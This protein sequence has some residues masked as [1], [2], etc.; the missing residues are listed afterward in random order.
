MP[1][2]QRRSARINRTLT[3]RAGDPGHSASRDQTVTFAG[4]TSLPGCPA[5]LPGAAIAGRVLPQRLSPRPCYLADCRSELPS[6][7]SGAMQPR[8]LGGNTAGEV[9]RQA[10]D[11]DRDGGN[12]L[13]RLATYGQHGVV[14]AVPG[15]Q[16]RS[17]SLW[18]ELPCPLRA[19]YGLGRRTRIR[20]RPATPGTISGDYAL[21][22]RT[23]SCMAPAHLSQARGIS[24]S[25]SRSSFTVPR[26]PVND[27]CH[28]GRTRYPHSTSS[29]DSFV[30]RLV[31]HGQHAGVPRP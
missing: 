8:D 24:R 2:G 22:L 12:V 27:R 20:A 19:S 23:A 5:R 28:R 14:L 10:S 11:D 29:A 26:R 13:G 18:A 31:C 30:R 21:E 1:R 17:G 4:G 3:M 15:R 7:M 6:V 16:V 9:V 25:S